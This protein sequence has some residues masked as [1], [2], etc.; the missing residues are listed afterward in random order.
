M[1]NIHLQIITP[2]HVV[3]DHKVKTVIIPGADGDFGALNGH[4]NLVAAVK[5]GLLDVR[6]GG[7]GTASHFYVISAGVAQVQK[8]HCAILVNYATALNKCDAAD[9]IHNKL[10]KL[11]EELKQ[12][13][14]RYQRETM[15]SEIDY[16]EA[17]A[18]LC[19]H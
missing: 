16:L 5:P 12:T 1:T 8:E 14:G 4:E 2:S 10:S 6:V 17:M 3:Y 7:S 13:E 9:S 19:K 18:Q 11:K 15:Q